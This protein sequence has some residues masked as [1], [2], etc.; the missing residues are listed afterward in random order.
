MISRPV[1]L[2]VLS[3]DLEDAKL[4]ASRRQMLAT[5]VFTLIILIAASFGARQMALKIVGTEARV[6]FN[7]LVNQATNAIQERMQLYENALYGLQGL[8]AASDSV[9]RDEFHAYISKENLPQRYPGLAAVRF[10]EHVGREDVDAFISAVRKDT[11]VSP[12]GYPD[13]QVHPAGERSSYE[14]IKYAE[15]LEDIEKQLGFD[16]SSDPARCEALDRARDTGEMASTPNLKSITDPSTY[17][18][19]LFLPI[20]KND[21]PLGSIGE[22]RAALLGF[23]SGTFN[24]RLLFSNILTSRF[25]HPHFDVEIFDSTDISRSHLLYDEDENNETP[26]HLENLRFSKNVPLEV[27]GR[28][29]TLHFLAMSGFTASREVELLPKV[30]FYA[31]LLLSFLIFGILVSLSTSRR[32]A[33]RL[34]NQMT[35]ELKDARDSALKASRAK[36]DFLASMSHEIR[37]PMNSVVGMADLLSETPLGHEQQEYVQVLKRGSEALLELINDILD[38]SKVESGHLKLEEIRFDL[39][40]FIDKTL[41]FISIRAHQKGLV[42][43]RVIDPGV[44]R[45]IGGDP[46]RLRQILTNLLGNAVKFT[47]KG[48]I[49]LEIKAPENAGFP[50]LLFSVR[51]TGI[52]IAPEKQ[53]LIFAPFT[54]ADSSTTRRY[55]GT[56]LGLSICK[57]LVEMMGGRLWVESAPGTGSTFYFTMQYKNANEIQGEILSSAQMNGPYLGPMNILL[58]EDAPDNRLLVQTY[59]KKFPYRID[60]AEN[61]KEAVEKSQSRLYDLI[62]MDIRMPVMDGY[63]ATRAIR[64]R[65]NAAGAAHVPI[66]ALT[67]DALKDEVL[68]TLAAGCDEHLTKPIR[69]ADLLA[70]ISRYAPS[71]RKVRNA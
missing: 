11:S 18:F 15:P 68:K 54:Q 66:L 59:L 16:V 48:V 67:A 6:E 30:V 52:G 70:A 55:G 32:R 69:K 10:I 2:P 50:A 7:S 53:P 42:L 23:V 31:G 12:A 43:K 60:T 35:A 29:W 1:K 40:E 46:A 39:H 25:R 38:L 37:T 44:P 62:L 22:K 34:A 26:E 71:E 14:I 65:E 8:F 20:Y 27:G 24:P 56:G 21:M 9:E 13:F 28:I 5:P 64:A 57:K 49:T 41:E 4:Q 3:A 63:A 17:R 19:N 47:E 61:G 51:D 33:L 36:S 45:F 58:V